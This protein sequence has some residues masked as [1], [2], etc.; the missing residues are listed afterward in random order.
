MIVC[1]GYIVDMLSFIVRFMILN[2]KYYVLGMSDFMKV[3]LCLNW[4]FNR[5]ILLKNGGLYKC[6]Y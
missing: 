2:S 1:Y 6:V 3:C 5:S 4:Y